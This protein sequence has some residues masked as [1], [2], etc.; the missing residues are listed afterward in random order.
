M[1]NMMNTYSLVTEPVDAH[2]RVGSTPGNTFAGRLQAHETV[3]Q[4][5]TLSP[6]DEIHALVGGTFLVREGVCRG[7]ITWRLP[8]KHLFERGGWERNDPPD[9]LRPTEPTKPRAGYNRQEVSFEH[10]YVMANAQPYGRGPVWVL[11]D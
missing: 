6:G 1:S 9:S 7:E 3:Y 2:I 11:R 4:V 10:A 5:L 8:E